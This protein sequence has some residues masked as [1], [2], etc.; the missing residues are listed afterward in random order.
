MFESRYKYFPFGRELNTHIKTDFGF[1]LP[2]K[3]DNSGTPILDETHT[4]SKK[5]YIPDWRYMEDYIKSLPY[6]DRI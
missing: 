3:R 1:V 6:S 4:Y 2:V 5:G